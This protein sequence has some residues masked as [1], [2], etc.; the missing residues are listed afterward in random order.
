MGSLAPYPETETLCSA[1]GVDPLGLIGSGS[2]LI[3]VRPENAAPLL[4]RLTEAGI[5]AREIGR[6]T[7]TAPAGSGAVRAGGG[8]TPEAAPRAAAPATPEATATPGAAS[9]AMQA[10]SP[11]CATA[12]RF[13]SRASR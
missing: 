8:A 5:D 10:A 1:L 13:P 6:A 7:E 4:D 11:P 9:P 3:A 2:L 12:G